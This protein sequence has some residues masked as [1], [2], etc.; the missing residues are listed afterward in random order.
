M[1]EKSFAVVGFVFALALAFPASAQTNTVTGDFT[2]NRFVQLV[3]AIESATTW[4]IYYNA[5]L[6]DTVPVN[7]IVRDREVPDILAEVFANTDFHYAADGKSNIFIT[8]GRELQTGLPDDFF[9]T[10]KTKEN[11]YNTALL[12]YLNDNKKERARLAAEAKLYEIG[13]RTKT[14]GTG[15]ASLAGYVKAFESGEPIVGAAVYIENPS[16][17]VTTDQFGYFS[18]IIPKGRHDLLIKSLG[19]KNTKRQI[20]VYTDGTLDIEVQEKITFRRIT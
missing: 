18:M 14:I 4:K 8:R 17:G 1:R 15:N 7:L 16:I 13:K 12:D 11:H 9:D 10:D 5:S 19:A 20:V 3:N 6:M 2:G